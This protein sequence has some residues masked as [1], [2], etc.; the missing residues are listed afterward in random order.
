LTT[1]VGFAGKASLSSGAKKFAHLAEPPFSEKGMV[2]WTVLPLRFVVAW[3]GTV[4][5]TST[6]IA[7]PKAAYHEKFLIDIIFSSK[8]FLF[9]LKS[10]NAVSKCIDD[11][12]Y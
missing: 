6:A 5:L 12:F 2:H 7:I 9:L 10:T 1:T 4:R 3:T 11:D 8:F